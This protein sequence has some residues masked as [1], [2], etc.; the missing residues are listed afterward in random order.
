[1]S[2][3]LSS[4]KKSLSISGL[5]IV[6][7]FNPSIDIHQLGEIKT[8]LMIGPKEPFFWKI[9]TESRE[10]VD[11]EIDPLDRWSERI[12]SSIAKEHRIKTY[13]PF[14]KDKN[15]PFYSWALE[16]D[17]IN[18]SPIKLLVHNEKGLFISFRGALG[19][20]H[21]IL[22]DRQPTAV[23]IGCSKPCENSCPIEAVN[24]KGYN[25]KKCIEYI[26]KSKN[27]ECLSG[28]LVRKSCPYGSNLQPSNQSLFHMN[29]F[30]KTDLVT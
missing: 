11:G 10:Y 24:S 26:S 9:F 3:R 30:L 1:M 8:M 13:F 2:N 25:A 18:S 12:L 29:S 5:E 15:W 19:L 21:K 14:D 17:E 7:T 22:P 4:I 23:C 28:C 20:N 6:G 16:C 27:K